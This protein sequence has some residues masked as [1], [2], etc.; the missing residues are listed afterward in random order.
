MFRGDRYKGMWAVVDGVMLQVQGLTEMWEPIQQEKMLLAK[1]L[2][3]GVVLDEEQMAF[4]ADN[5]DTVTICQA[6][7]ELTTIT[8]F[9]IDELDAFDSD[10]DEAP[11]AS[12]ILMAKLS[13][14]D[15]DMHYYEQPPF[16]NDSDIDITSDS[17]VISYNQYLQ[18]TENKVVQDTTSS[19]QQDAMI[20]SVIEEMSN[21]VAKCNDSDMYYYEQPPFINDSDIDITSD[22]N[23]ISY[24]QYLQETEN[25]VV[26]DTTSSAQQ[27][28]MI[29]SVIEKM[30]NQVAKCNEVNQENKTI[31][32]SLAAELERYKEQI[33]IFEERQKFNLTDREK[34]INGQMRALG[35]QNPLYLTQAQRQQPSLYCGHTIVR[36]HDALFVLDTK[37]TLKL[38][39]ESKLKMLAK[40]NDLIAKEK[41]VNMAPI[42]YDA[43]NKLSEHFVKHFVLKKQ[44]SAEQAFWLPISKLVSEKPRFNPNQLRRKFLSG[45]EHIWG[46]FKKD[47]KPFVKTLKE[48]FHMFDQGLAKEITDMREVFN[49]METEVI[50]YFVDKKYFEIKKKELFIENDRLLE[51][52]ICQDAMCIAMHADLDNKCI[53]PAN[54]NHLEYAKMEQSYIDE[55]SK[56]LELEA[57]LSKKKDMVEKDVYNELSK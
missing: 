34:Y 32:E 14:Y 36:K 43:L 41:K 46:A 4:L 45:F 11:L 9:Q 26:Q 1:A 5:E 42:D 38:A 39:E 3:S 55:Y 17:N 56:A 44:L 24:N 19:A 57:K 15:S 40:Q 37:E 12:A 22:S 48:Y 47:V 21:Q 51:H 16:I 23:V 31:N 8:I 50:K 30:S 6:S 29:M 13:A 28:A 7:Q 27:D 49:Q 53:V 35:Y 25:K 20:M 54:D 52:I 18:E 2:E 10:C 33:K